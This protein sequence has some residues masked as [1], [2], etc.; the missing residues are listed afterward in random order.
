MTQDLERHKKKSESLAELVE[1]YRPSD[2]GDAAERASRF[3]SADGEALIRELKEKLA[4][5][6]EGERDLRLMLNVYQTSG[7]DSRQQKE[8][9]E[10]KKRV[11]ESFW[12]FVCNF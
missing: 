7:K 9:R 8:V 6:E 4:T 5:A 10:G 3:L 2:E 1:K 11:G 12:C